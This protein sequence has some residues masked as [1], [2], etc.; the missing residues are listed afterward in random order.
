MAEEDEDRKRTVSVNTTVRQKKYEYVYQ[1]YLS[2]VIENENLYTKIVQ[3]APRY[4]LVN[5]MKAA[6]CVAQY[7][8]TE[9]FEILEPN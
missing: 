7:G 1:T 6:I 2:L 4:V 5:R 9:A 8:C 3:I